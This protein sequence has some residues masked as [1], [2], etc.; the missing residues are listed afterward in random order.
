MKK[1]LILLFLVPS[2]S[3]GFNVTKGKIYKDGSDKYCLDCTIGVFT[4]DM[5]FNGMKKKYG[6][7]YFL[8][9]NYEINI[10]A[11][12]VPGLDLTWSNTFKIKGY[13]HELTAQDSLY[14]KKKGTKL[15]IETKLHFDGN[16][17]EL[18]YDIS[19]TKEVDAYVTKLKSEINLNN[20]ITENISICK[21]YGFTKGTELFQECILE[22]L[23]TEK[24]LTLNQE[25]YQTYDNGN[26]IMQEKAIEEQLRLQNSLDLM[27]LGLD[28]LNQGNSNSSTTLNIPPIRCITNP[29]GWSCM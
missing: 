1:L 10:T 5:I 18:P 14:I 22:I 8:K 3:W 23:R 28:I 2:L 4:A 7:K 13:L 19:S 9:G 21:R 17:Y 15:F 12:K 26:I 6:Y 24:L 29:V 25:K 16:V 20:Q 27:R 11:G